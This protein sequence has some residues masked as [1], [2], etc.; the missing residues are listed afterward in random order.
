[1]PVV[2]VI[3]VLSKMVHLRVQFHISK[4]KIEDLLNEELN[5]I[6]EKQIADILL[7]I[8]KNIEQQK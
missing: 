1:M 7:G 6:S 2:N 5:G 8:G 3:I 4:E